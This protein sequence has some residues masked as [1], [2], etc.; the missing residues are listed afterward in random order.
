LAIVAVFSGK[1][2]MLQGTFVEIFAPLKDPR[3]NRTKKHLFL[4]IIGLSLFAV[5]AGAQCYTEIEDFC[6]HHKAWLKNYFLLPNGIPSHDTFSRVFSAI[7]PNAFQ[8]CFFTWIKSIIELLPENV[9]AIDGK[10]IRAS[11][12]VRE[13][14]KALHIVNAWSCA[15]GISL[16]QMKVDEKTNE[17]TVIPDILKKLCIEGAI[18]TLDAMGC[19][20][21]IAEQIIEQKG[22]YV[23]RVKANQGG[24]QDAMETTF[25]HA[26]SLKYEAMTYYTAQDETNND[27]GRIESRRCII[28]PLMY[29]MKMKL[30]WKGLKSLVLVISERET[31]EGNTVEYRYYISS[32][33]PKEPKKILQSIRNHWQVENNLHWVLDVA[34]REDQSRIRDENSAL[35]MSWLRKT[36]LGL[37][38]R[39]TNI[40]GGIR[41]KQLAIWAKPEYLIDIVKI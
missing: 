14:L 27:H 1:E 37:L 24:L 32:L 21:E 15:N 6:R 28:L 18:I 33:D 8:E 29:L 38:K 19:Q 4:D 10:S 22:D 34:Y 26:D 41:R 39:A 2:I 9:I 35:N 31:H 13:G 23:L 17:I 12:R 25:K 20:R 16:G 11:K 5:L 40:K 36:S 3:V 7:N 30:K